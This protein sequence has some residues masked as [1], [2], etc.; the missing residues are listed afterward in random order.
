MDAESGSKIHSNTRPRTLFYQVIAV[1]F[2]CSEP[3][4]ITNALESLQKEPFLDGILIGA[5]ANRLTP[6][7]PN[8]TLAESEIAQP[9][10]DD[11]TPQ[12]YCDEFASPWK[13]RLGVQL[14]GGCCGI[15]PQHIKY[16][17]EHLA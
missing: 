9:M 1:L 15:T 13:N 16:L 17:N 14:I 8:W 12:K 7:D 3:E 4:V 6:V 2:N 5:Y 10:R 11:M